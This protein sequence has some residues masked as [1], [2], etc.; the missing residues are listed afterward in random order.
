MKINASPQVEKNCSLGALF[1]HAL[2]F[3]FFSPAAPIAELLLVFTESLNSVQTKSGVT[4][5]PSNEY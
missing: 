5:V 1:I 4:S 3:V 2:F